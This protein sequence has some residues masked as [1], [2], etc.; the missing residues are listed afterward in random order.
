MENAIRRQICLVVGI[1][2][3]EQPFRKHFSELREAPGKSHCESKY[4]IGDPKIKQGRQFQNR[5]RLSG[6]GEREPGAEHEKQ[7]PAKWVE[8]PAAVRKR[9]QIPFELTRGKIQ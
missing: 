2:G 4:Q 6:S 1:E 7:L 3:V 9:R 8:I 5:A